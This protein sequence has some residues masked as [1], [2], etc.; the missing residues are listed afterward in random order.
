MK[1]LLLVGAILYSTIIFAQQAPQTNSQLSVNLLIP[2]LEYEM[3]MGKKTTLDLNLGTGFAYRSTNND[4]G[5]AVFPTFHA[6]YRFYYNLDKRLEKGKKI[7]EN[8]GNY[9][10]ALAEITSGNP[11]F[12]DLKSQADYAVFI[13]PAWGLQRVYN[14]GFKLNINLGG[15]IGFNDL[16]DSYFSP[17]VGLQ[18]GWLILK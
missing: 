8:S 5:Y 12:G 17:F 2:S 3:S 9:F 6:Q 15:G 11:I 7:S 18:L 16:G 1:N 13:G 14:S 4:S 10:T